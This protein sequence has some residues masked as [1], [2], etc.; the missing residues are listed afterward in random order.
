MGVILL[1]VASFIFLSCGSEIKQ[2][3]RLTTS[4]AEEKPKYIHAPEI[5]FATYTNNLRG[6]LLNEFVLASNIQGS[7]NIEIPVCIQKAADLEPENA[8]G[9][10]TISTSSLI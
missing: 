4:D 8:R 5:N 1:Y 3:A 6:S 7:S 2:E 10:K 9:F